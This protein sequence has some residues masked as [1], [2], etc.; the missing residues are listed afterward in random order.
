MC[1]RGVHIYLKTVFLSRPSLLVPL[2]VVYSGVGAFY[3]LHSFP[4]HLLTSPIQ[5]ASYPFVQRELVPAIAAATSLSKK[6]ALLIP[7]ETFAGETI[8][9]GVQKPE[10]ALR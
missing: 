2:Y 9:R 5:C 10:L 6:S 8:R 7:I 1:L 3:P 4:P